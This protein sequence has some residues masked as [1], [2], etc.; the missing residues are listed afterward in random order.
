M[1]TLEFIIYP[2]GRV[3]ERVLGI[4]GRECSV[5]TSAIEEKLGTVVS[6]TITAEYLQQPVPQSHQIAQPAHAF[7]EW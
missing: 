7:S 3:E 2:D 5:V 1:E 4:V 6:R